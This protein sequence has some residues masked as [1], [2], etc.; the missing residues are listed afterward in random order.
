[1]QE[2]L[3]IQGPIFHYLVSRIKNQFCG[4]RIFSYILNIC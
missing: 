4:I 3:I 2:E 1:M